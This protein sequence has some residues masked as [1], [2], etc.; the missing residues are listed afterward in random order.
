MRGVTSCHPTQGGLESPYEPK[1]T[2]PEA[3][4]YSTIWGVA[5]NPAQG[6]RV[7][8]QR[9]SGGVK[10]SDSTCDDFEKGG[11]DMP[12][13]VLEEVAARCLRQY[14][15]LR[16]LTGKEEM[17]RI[18]KERIFG[19]ERTKLGWPIAKRAFK[20]AS[21]LPPEG[22][23]V[24]TKAITFPPDCKHAGFTAILV[25]GTVIYT[26]V[27]GLFVVPERTLK[28]LKKMS[29]PYEPA[30]AETLSGEG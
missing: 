4:T 28:V 27:P 7:M 11:A 17:D 10:T 21:E 18:E 15:A 25:T 22:P 6:S 20:I 1:A 5:W 16:G 19:D 2:P 24:R 8:V 3:V 9:A 14:Q 29:I 12:V 26:N 13:Q 23:E 30:E